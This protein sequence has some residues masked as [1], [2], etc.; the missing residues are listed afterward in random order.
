MRAHARACACAFVSV[1]VSVI[2][3]SEIDVASLASKL[4]VATGNAHHRHCRKRK[5]ALWSGE[6]M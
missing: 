4:L 5:P 1:S 3:S 6:N 2:C